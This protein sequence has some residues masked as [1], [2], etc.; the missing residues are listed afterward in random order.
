MDNKSL[1]LLDNS[2]VKSGEAVREVDE[3]FSFPQVNETVERVDRDIKAI[4]EDHLV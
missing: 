4:T 2:A 3:E 1:L